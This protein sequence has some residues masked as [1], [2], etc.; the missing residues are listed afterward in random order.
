MRNWEGSGFTDSYP[1]EGYINRH[2]SCAFLQIVL[3]NL[4]IQRPF[5]DAEDFGRLFAVAVDQLEGV[6]NQF[7]FGLFDADADEV[8]HAAGDVAA[9]GADFGGE[10][11]DA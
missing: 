5:T 11:F 4:S 1:T 8:V 7:L 6:A 9:S 2:I 10:G 3:F